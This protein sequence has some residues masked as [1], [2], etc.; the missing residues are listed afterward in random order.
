MTL[1]A[2]AVLFLA[3]ATWAQAPIA[4]PV[5][6][7]KAEPPK[8][9]P[10]APPVLRNTGK[11]ML[12]PFQCTDDDIEWA[13]MS[14]TEEDPCPV[15]LE[16][17]TIETVGNRIIVLANIHSEATTLYSVLLASEDAG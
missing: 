14:C 2:V 1:T 13:G 3:C 4:P 6:L 11:P 5:E 8:T 7:P 16:V 17:S 15:Y 9:E 12:V 10:P